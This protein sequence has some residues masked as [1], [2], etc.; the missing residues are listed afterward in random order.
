MTLDEVCTRREALKKIGS[1]L[2]KGAAAVAGTYTVVSLADYV[3]GVEA[4]A[5]GSTHRIPGLDY[6][7]DGGVYLCSTSGYKTKFFVQKALNRKE[8]DLRF[9]FEVPDLYEF[10]GK[11]V[12]PK[13]ENGEL[14]GLGFNDNHSS[15]IALAFRIDGQLYHAYKKIDGRILALLQKYNK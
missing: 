12:Q 11:H 7:F 5:D 4:R 8:N 13:Y 3:C 6:V 1:W 9:L 10:V 2:G 15:E 14:L